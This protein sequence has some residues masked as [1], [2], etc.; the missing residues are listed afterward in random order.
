MEVAML[1]DLHK[2]EMNAL[3]DELTI[4]KDKLFFK[5]EEV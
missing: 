2:Q 4:Y 3:E 5:D 1:T